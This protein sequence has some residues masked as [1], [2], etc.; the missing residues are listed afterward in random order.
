MPTG[1]SDRLHGLRGCLRAA[2]AALALAGTLALVA[3][4]MMAAL[5][6]GGG[7]QSFREAQAA[8]RAYCARVKAGKH[9]H[10]NG[11]IDCGRATTTPRG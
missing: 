8:E 5:I 11:R 7:E 6:Y 1:S 2:L 9:R 3:L 4:A 10:Y